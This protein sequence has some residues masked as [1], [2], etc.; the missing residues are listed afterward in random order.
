MMYSYSGVLRRLIDPSAF[1]S[2]RAALDQG[3]FDQADSADSKFDFGLD[4][5]LDG[6]DVLVR[7][8]H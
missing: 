4:R 2:V 6:I 1:P 3:V 7:S 8:R 5:V